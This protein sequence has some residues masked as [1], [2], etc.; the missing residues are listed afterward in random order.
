MAES[1][2][3][4]ELTEALT[5]QGSC[6]AADN[7]YGVTSSDK[8]A[9]GEFLQGATKETRNGDVHKEEVEG[10]FE[11]DNKPTD[12]FSDDQKV[13][14]GFCAED[15]FQGDAPSYPAAREPEI[16]LGSD[17]AS[18]PP[19][20]EDFVGSNIDDSFSPFNSEI[21]SY[22]Q[23]GSH[24][25][26]SA[27]GG[28]QE[29][30]P[31]PE[32]L[33]D[34]VPP[35]AQKNELIDFSKDEDQAADLGF[36]S[37]NPF[38]NPATGQT[39]QSDPYSQFQPPDMGSKKT[40]QQSIQSPLHYDAPEFYPQ[41]HSN[42]DYSPLRH[43]AP[44]FVSRAS[45]QAAMFDQTGLQ[46]NELPEYSQL[47][48][49]KT[50]AQDAVDSK[51]TVPTSMEGWNVP[52]A[53]MQ[54]EQ[55]DD[56]VDDDDEED[57]SESE[58]NSQVENDEIIED[59]YTDS[60]EDTENLQDEV[61]CGAGEM[62]QPADVHPEFDPSS[63]KQAFNENNE[64]DFQ[65]QI[66][67]SMPSAGA[68]PP[69]AEG[70]TEQGQKD[71][72][73]TREKV[74]LQNP[75]ENQQETSGDLSRDTLSKSETFTIES[76]SDME[77][78][79]I[80][81]VEEN[82]VADTEGA[83][84]DQ[85]VSGYQDNLT[86]E[87][88]G[89]AAPPFGQNEIEQT[90][91][92]MQ[93]QEN[94]FA[95]DMEACPAAF[96]GDEN[97]MFTK[98]PA[99]PQE[100]EK[101]QVTYQDEKMPPLEQ[102]FNNET[103]PNEVYSEEPP[104][105]I[106]Q[107]ISPLE[108]PGH[109]DD[110]ASPRDVLLE[111]TSKQELQMDESVVDDDKAMALD[112]P[113]RQQ[114]IPQ[115]TVFTQ[116]NQEYEDEGEDEGTYP[117]DQ[118]SE[119]QEDF[120][121]DDD[122]EEE[123]VGRSSEERDEY[124]Q[125]QKSSSEE[126]DEY[127]QGQKSS[128]EERD[129]YA[130]GQKLSS[131]ER[132]EY[133]QEQKLSSEERD[134]YLQEQ[135]LSS[136]ERDEYPQEQKLASE[137]R[138]EYLQEQKLPSE[139]RDEYPQEQKLPSEERSVSPHKDRM[140]VEKEFSPEVGFASGEKPASAQQNTNEIQE[141]VTP[142]L[143]D[144][145]ASDAK[146]M[147]ASESQPVYGQHPFEEQGAF[148]EKQ[149]VSQT[150]EEDSIPME[151]EMVPGRSE[152][153]TSDELFGA[154]P[155]PSE[156]CGVLHPD[157]GLGQEADTFRD[158]QAAVIPSEGSQQRQDILTAEGD[159]DQGREYD[160]RCDIST[161]A[162]VDDFDK[163]EQKSDI[164]TS[165]GVNGSDQPAPDKFDDEDVAVQ[166]NV[167]DEYPQQM[168]DFAQQNITDDFAL[169]NVEDD[170]ARQN[171]EDD[172]A[173]QNITDEFAQQNITNDFQQQNVEDNFAQQNITDDF[174]QQN[175]TND[176]Q[177]QNVEDNFAQQNIT[178]D[179]AQQNFTNDFQQ[180]NVQDDFPQ[181]ENT[182]EF[183]QQNITNL[184][185]QNDTND[186]KQK[187]VKDDFPQQNVKDDFPQ[188][189]V[190]DDFPQQNVEDD[191]PQ[192]NVKDD[193]PQQNVK[194]DFPQQNV[195]DD[196][197]KQMTEN[198]Y[199]KPETV[200]HDIYKEQKEELLEAVSDVRETCMLESDSTAGSLKTYNQSEVPAQMADLDKPMNESMQGSIY[201]EDD[202][203]LNESSMVLKETE[204]IP[205]SLSQSV[206]TALEEHTQDL[207]ED[208]EKRLKELAESAKVD[209]QM[210][211]EDVAIKEEAVSHKE[212]TVA[213]EPELPKPTTAQQQVMEQS[214]TTSVPEPSIAE[215]VTE[216]TE[217]K[218]P[219]KSDKVTKGQSAEKVAKKIAEPAEKKTPATD[220]SDK[221]DA[222]VKKT[223][224]PTA[225]TPQKPLRKPKEKTP[226][227]SEPS[228]I[229][230]PTKTENRIP[231]S[232]T[233]TAR[234]AKTASPRTLDVKPST[235]KPPFDTSFPRAVSASSQRIA[236]LSQTPTT[237]S[238]TK[239]TSKKLPTRTQ[240]KEATESFLERMS[241]PRCRTPKKDGT[242]DSGFEENKTQRAA[243]ATS[244]RKKYGI[245]AKNDNYKP[246]GG[247][248]KITDQKVTVKHVGSRIDARS[249]T[250]TSTNRDHT[251][252]TT[253]KGPTPDT[254]HVQSK[255]GSLANATH[256]PG[257]G[258]VRIANQK[259][260]YSAV[261][262]KIGSKVNLDHR[263]KGG[264][265][266]IMSQ[267]L[268]WK[269]ASRVGSLDNAKHSPGGGK[270]KIETAKLDFKEKAAS[271]VGSKDNMDHKAGGGDKKIETKK[272]DFKEKA[273]SKVGSK[274]NATHKPGGGDK[275]IES[276][277]LTFKES[278]KP[279]TDTGSGPVTS[280]PQSK[281]PSL[282]SP[283]PD[284]GIS[285]DSLPEEQ[286][287]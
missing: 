225:K 41:Q 156:Q 91:S 174:V 230:S 53:N 171:V 63:I 2:S 66:G 207:G 243:S 218:L 89:G 124:A 85:N 216:K 277:K 164:L 44:E 132:D 71:Q 74:N 234:P 285:H 186:F 1:S 153:T 226:P 10:G 73:D 177:Q 247:N 109:S 172:F 142:E 65:Q 160:Q 222:K 163:N 16:P 64:L 75:V 70:F 128:S 32:A 167:T 19:Q 58:S 46:G 26:F 38:G 127:P 143:K 6:Q 17:A 246:G 25:S 212:N 248:V 94:S 11:F 240:T 233:R 162:G 211:P 122:E 51:E 144:S 139:E 50:P 256:T 235:D 239:V 103:R 150:F 229:P 195:E 21:S 181:K 3:V 43:D 8:M 42:A 97:D 22:S 201:K 187:N 236:P 275:K 56:Y 157:Q 219:E 134:E 9:D 267:K 57:Y 95:S 148:D 224:K 159:F 191:F 145:F 154:A 284:S 119:D 18:F 104:M 287:S 199:Q 254:K 208:G 161:A 86:N 59:D 241:R 263:P 255:I 178:D 209:Q 169:Q 179:F 185:Q 35:M 101:E 193:F 40:E 204:S 180:Q 52:V 283:R 123:Y 114:D 7:L 77:K 137:E 168:D 23:T 20:C 83:A 54:T 268:E 271:K 111:E 36:V 34:P 158:E 90:T 200:T 24:E 141:N 281:S 213:P 184:L 196:F 47:D 69:L 264:D 165:G 138:D 270:V 280:P 117:D 175:I 110:V 228:K 155:A 48:T 286:E 28:D 72:I 220:K 152:Q 87:E 49:S 81:P 279:R 221:K 55:A 78:R 113:A 126:R 27:F 136:E 192:Q 112:E 282:K 215:K 120:I 261:Q 252:R 37:S 106:Q 105:F 147:S 116:Q 258:N 242:S 121:D 198:D 88:F 131:E 15:S 278:A 93:K 274:D 61:V 133:L 170:F 203:S 12:R 223:E 253:P 68:D 194:D 214:I 260:D 67:S 245:D 14:T 115:N 272:L 151:H 182:D 210:A 197:P 276:H 173:R 62:G 125:G 266:K 262:G 98:S 237:P 146:M 102:G 176:F 202:A 205:S 99:I 238:P 13:P 79:S 118:N 96:H 140:S 92:P 265:K 129:E 5:L 39:H 76:D 107:G 249:K 273:T 206:S 250:P 100:A 130:Q 190:K 227:K 30:E 232:T 269:A 166:Q 60:E 259:K 189:N 244:Q 82:M 4:T 251:P 188:Q 33:P 45:Q 29:M 80:T 217:E 31:T 108:Q 84:S 149:P 257:G 231:K 135:K 183:A